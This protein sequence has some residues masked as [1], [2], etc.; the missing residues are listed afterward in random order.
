MVNISRLSIGNLTFKFLLLGLGLTL[1]SSCII[2]RTPGF[3]SGYKRLN[4][5]E[6]SKV[7]ILNDLDAIPVFIDSNTYAITAKHLEQILKKSPKSIVYF[8]SPNC[9]ANAC[10]SIPAFQKFCTSYGYNPIIISEYFDYEMLDIQ[11]VKPSSVFAINHWH[12]K[13]DYCNTY[14]RKFKESLFKLFN[15]EFKKE[16]YSQYLYYDGNVFSINKPAEIT[17]YPWQN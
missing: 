17:K 7:V 2:T 5:N 13:T 1:I 11:G 12:Y 6:K 9:T 16:S 8:W 4:Q 3:Y 15:A 14:V 10:I